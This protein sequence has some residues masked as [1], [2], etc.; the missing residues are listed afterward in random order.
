VS[1]SEP[2]PESERA[3]A[4]KK[5]RSKRNARARVQRSKE[6]RQAAIQSGEAKFVS[7]REYS[8]LT[9]LHIATV[10][11]RLK[12]EKLRFKKDGARVLIFADQ[13]D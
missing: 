1:T 13:L 6:R 9:G 3:L 7:P 2:E 4:I 8:E 12:A 5:L 11:R 10:H